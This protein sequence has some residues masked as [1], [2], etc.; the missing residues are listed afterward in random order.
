MVSPH[1]G[2]VVLVVAIGASLPIIC[3]ANDEP[4]ST[5]SSTKST[6]VFGDED[7]PAFVFGEDDYVLFP[8]GDH[9]LVGD[10]ELVLE[11]QVAPNIRVF[12]NVHAA[13]TEVFR[14]KD[15]DV[16]PEDDKPRQ[17]RKC[18]KRQW[19]RS[20]FGTIMF[21]LRMY[22]D[23]SNPVRTPSFMPKI[24]AQWVGLKSLSDPYKKQAR[25]V[26][27]RV[28]VA[29]YD[30]VLGH[31]SNGQDGCLFEIEPHEDCRS[32]TA[33]TDR[34]I[35]THDGS[36]STN[37]VRLG[38]YWGWMTIGDDNDVVTQRVG[39]GVAG[40]YH[41]C[42]GCKD[43][44]WLKEPLRSLYGDNRVKLT[45]DYVKARVWKFHRLE[46]RIGLDLIVDCPDCRHMYTLT[47]EIIA[48]KRS[49]NGIG[50]YL[51]FDNG[52]DYYNVAFQG[53]RKRVTVG[54]AFNLGKFLDFTPR[55]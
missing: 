3:M 26:G 14:V 5:K 9:V 22:N 37:Y 8:D 31:Y 11:A 48:Q 41:P 29:A 47:A 30:V 15:G 42:R 1:S 52:R 40:E 35:N 23:D 17:R 43:G 39:F 28:S 16:C 50:Y 34:E 44:G 6:V 32:I 33:W 38:G 49:W 19:G 36:F 13:T 25:L 10:K 45:F 55:L 21:R 4:R 24:T 2:I 27:S 53:F 20:V 18:F 54:V 12:S 46:S 7:Y 51:R